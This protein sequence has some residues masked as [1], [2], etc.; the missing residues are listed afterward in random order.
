MSEERL[1]KII[2]KAERMGERRR[3]KLRIGWLERIKN[4]LKEGV[5]STKCRKTW[6]RAR[7]RVVEAIDVCRDRVKRRSIL[8]AYPARDMA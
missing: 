8:S 4:I 5:R 6:M 2:Y 3:G 1:T 7:M